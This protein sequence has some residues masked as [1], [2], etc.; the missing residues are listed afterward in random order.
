MTERCS[1]SWLGATG[2][3]LAAAA[4]AATGFL[5][6]RLLFRVVDPTANLLHDAMITGVAA[7]AVALI[8]SRLSRSCALGCLPLAAIGGLFFWIPLL[9]IMVTVTLLLV[10]ATPLLVQALAGPRR[11]LPRI[12]QASLLVLLLAGGV[13]ATAWPGRLPRT[14]VLQVAVTQAG[15]VYALTAQLLRHQAGSD[16]WERVELPVSGHSQRFLI[17]RVDQPDEAL[18]IAGGQLWSLDGRGNSTS[19]GDVPGY[20]NGSRLVSGKGGIY[21]VASEASQDSYRYWLRVWSGTSDRW[22]DYPLV[23]K[24][25]PLE[26]TPPRYLA[27]SPDEPGV[28]AI[29]GIVGE[30][31]VLWLSRDYGRSWEAANIPPRLQLGG[32]RPSIADLAFVP[33]RRGTLVAAVSD[34]VPSQILFRSDDYGKIWQPLAAPTST[35]VYA[36]VAVAPLNPPAIY[37]HAYRYSRVSDDFGKSWRSLANRWLPEVRDGPIWISMAV[38]QRDPKGLY[39]CSSLGLYYTHDLGRSWQRVL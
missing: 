21:A 24:G 13:A 14:E 9:G 35:A 27:A 39:V 11:P 19:L 8:V 23:S 16:R 15:T 7:G 3:A 30:N 17:A 31:R 18:C 38:D 25:Q 37:Y 33:G 36:Q 28:V 20:M 4:L 26:V 34:Q 2:Q 10:T 5:L 32:S 6:S 1:H 12:W 22:K 29:W